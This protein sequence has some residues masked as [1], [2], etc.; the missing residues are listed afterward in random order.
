MTGSGEY[1]NYKST[2]PKNKFITT[3]VAITLVLSCLAHFLEMAFLLFPR[4]GISF[5]YE[6]QLKH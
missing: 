2:V 5:K 3:S 6:S 1:L 4:T